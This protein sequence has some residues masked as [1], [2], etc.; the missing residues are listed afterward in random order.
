MKHPIL[1]LFCLCVVIAIAVCGKSTTTPS[2]TGSS[3]SG[4]G[5]GSNPPTTVPAISDA[6]LMFCVS[7]TNRYRAMLSRAPLTR[8]S[9]LEAYATDGARIDQQANQPHQHFISGNGGGVALAENEQ[10]IPAN[11]T[12]STQSAMASMLS[13]F[14]SEGPGGGHYQNIMGGSTQVGCGVYRTADVMTITE[15]FR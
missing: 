3:S 10:T 12:V 9:A 2:S 5:S 6:D 8:S 11:T 4:G 7:E 1:R 14:Y 15:D 13:L